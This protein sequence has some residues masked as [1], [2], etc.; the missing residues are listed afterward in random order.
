MLVLGHLLVW[1]LHYW[2]FCRDDYGLFV[3]NMEKY[4]CIFLLFDDLCVFVCAAEMK[5]ME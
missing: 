3:V 4:E 1:L 5:D 2:G